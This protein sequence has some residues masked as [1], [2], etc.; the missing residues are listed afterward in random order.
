MCVHIS[1]VLCVCT[2]CIKL[3][4]YRCHI[5]IIVRSRCAAL[6]VHDVRPA[7]CRSC[8]GRCYA[9]P[10]RFTQARRSLQH[11]PRFRLFA[12]MCSLLDSPRPAALRDQPGLSAIAC[13]RSID[14]SPTTE[15]AQRGSLRGRRNNVQ[16]R[17]VK[18]QAD[19]SRIS[20]HTGGASG[21]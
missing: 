18:K 15:I 1:S 11:C 3:S 16:A 12:S 10:G 17:P 2:E 4:M 14:C 8:C 6:I 21:L 20:G 13:K 9:T 7:L 19:Q 5:Y